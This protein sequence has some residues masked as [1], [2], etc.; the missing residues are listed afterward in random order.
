MLL[1]LPQQQKSDIPPKQPEGLRDG[2][3]LYKYQLDAVAWMK[4][5]EDEVKE[6]AKFKQCSLIPWRSA[7]T[8]VLY[9]TKSKE[10]V[11]FD[12]IPKYIHEFSPKG[13]ALADEVSLLSSSELIVD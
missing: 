3:N 7:K 5:I 9:D 8:E 4:S 12:E 2:L 13:G 6:G 10:F 11:T 1:F